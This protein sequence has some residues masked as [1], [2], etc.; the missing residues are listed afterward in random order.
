MATARIRG[1][2]FELRAATADLLLVALSSAL[3]LVARF[4]GHVPANYWRAEAVFVAVAVAVTVATHAGHLLYASL[5]A[6]ASVIEAR[7]LVR[8]TAV[9]TLLLVAVDLPHRLVPLS[10]ILFGQLLYLLL[11]GGLRFRSRLFLRRPAAGASRGVPAVVVG[12][13]EAGAALIRA[14]R[15]DPDVYLPVAALD[16]DVSNHGKV[17]LGVPV[18]G[19]VDSLAELVERTKAEQV[20][21]AVPSADQ[22]LI[23]RVADLCDA[24]EV[25]LRILPQ[26]S[27]LVPGRVQLAD[28]RELQIDDLLGR[29]QRSTDLA[30]VYSLIAGKRVLITGAGG[31]I[32]SEI[33][34][35]VAALDPAEVYLLDHDETHLHDTMSKLGAPGTQL[36]ADVRERAVIN[37]IFAERRPEVVF[38]A[39]AHKHVPLL[40]SHPIEA[41]RTNVCGTDNVVAAAA[42][43]GT[44]TFVFVSTDKAVSPSS[45]MGASKRIGEQVVLHARP[46]GAR[47]CAVRFGNVLGSRGSVVPTFI[48]QISEGGPVTI[49]D[50]RMTRFFMSIPEAVALV[51]QAAT[52]SEGGEIFMLD[53]GNPVPIVQLAE[54]LIRMQG[55]RVGTDIE[56]RVTGVRPGE[57]LHEVLAEADEL[58]YPTRHPA[59]TRLVPSPLPA[60]DIAGA[61][62][63][64]TYLCEHAREEDVRELVMDLAHSRVERHRDGLLRLGFRR[65]ASDQDAAA[66]RSADR[67]LCRRTSDLHASVPV[68][69]GER[70]IVIADSSI[71]NEAA[72]SS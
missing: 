20:L 25:P 17:L 70:T 72:I 14:M 16:D 52:L 3:A 18:V 54:R 53:M 46:E 5:W 59:V 51:L 49:T 6:H 31:S 4:D 37:R 61:V 22:E 43:V 10:V 38:H 62:R 1:R 69:A 28:L 19:S 15:R 58:P 21:L 11:A 48:R 8:S 63:A 56:I 67:R 42:A 65:R 55:L 29:Q 40:E 13:G 9:A 68:Q 34:R 36:L 2:R 35:Q 32:G 33:A 44:D 24:A 12:V 57:K 27:E 45:V 23:R 7:R 66:G 64:F 47:Y 30:A 26:V 41:A 39:A 71:D 60:G 50:P